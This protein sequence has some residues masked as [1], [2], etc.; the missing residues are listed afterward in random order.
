VGFTVT[1]A[2]EAVVNVHRQ[3]QQWSSLGLSKA[4]L[5]FCKWV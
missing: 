2:A 3:Q 4:D 5:S 1:A